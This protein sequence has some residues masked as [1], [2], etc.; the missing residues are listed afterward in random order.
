MGIALVGVAQTFLWVFLVHGLLSLLWIAMSFVR[1]QALLDK[2]TEVLEAL[3]L[4]HGLDAMCCLG[5][6][7]TPALDAH[8]P[9]LAKEHR[10]QCNKSFDA[11]LSSSRKLE[12]SQLGS[13][14]QA[15]LEI[16]QTRATK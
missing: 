8:A 13:H 5:I 16:C 9:V 4:G 15:S 7:C 2:L 12:K 3:G 6:R 1:S 11:S 10:R 14:F